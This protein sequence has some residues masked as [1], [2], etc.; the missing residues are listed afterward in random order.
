LKRASANI[1]QNVPP[2]QG[3]RIPAYS[4]SKPTVSIVA[5]CA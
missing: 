5:R 3:N 1:S 2:N 4:V